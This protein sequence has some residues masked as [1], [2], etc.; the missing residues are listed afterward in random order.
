MNLLGC[1]GAVI[2]FVTGRFFLR[3]D[4][5]TRYDTL[6]VVNSK[7]LKIRYENS[8]YA[9]RFLKKFFLRYEISEK[10]LFTLWG[11]YRC[12]MKRFFLRYEI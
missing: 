11:L 1:N 3:Y 7:L 4:T 5:L 9:M 2:T 10:V 12:I 6:C 8:F